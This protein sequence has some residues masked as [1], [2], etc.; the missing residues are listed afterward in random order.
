MGE[1]FAY[2]DNSI[3]LRNNDCYCG[4]RFEKVYK[5]M[6]HPK[7]DL[8]F[9]RKLSHL[10]KLHP[11]K[12]FLPARLG[13]KFRI[14]FKIN[15]FGANNYLFSHNPAKVYPSNSDS[16]NRGSGLIFGGLEKGLYS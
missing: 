16:Y 10:R 14:A 12:K 2:Q 11:Q 4:N 13:K 3:P 9:K 8:C 15:V 1:S 7:Q 5:S 6:H